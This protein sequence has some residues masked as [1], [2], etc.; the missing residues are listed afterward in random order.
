MERISRKP[1][2]GITNIIRFNW[3]Y[4]VIAFSVIATL[5]IANSYLPGTVRAVSTMILFLTILSIIIS[6][7][8][9]WYIY[10][11]SDLYTLNWLNNLSIGSNKQLVNINAGFDETSSTLKEKYQVSLMM[12][13]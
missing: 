10:D 2:Q 1:F 12:L 9:S 8:V 4:Y 13:S 5:L 6:L 11:Y 7:A 3:H